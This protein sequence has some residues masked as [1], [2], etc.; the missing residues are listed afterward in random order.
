VVTIQDI[1]HEKWHAFLDRI[2]FHDIL[3]TT[4]ALQLTLQL[5]TEYEDYIDKKGLIKSANRLTKELIE[6]ILSQR[7]LIDAESNHYVITINNFNSIDIIDDIF[8]TYVEHKLT[9][10]KTLKIALSSKSIDIYS[11]RTLLRLILVN[12]TK[13]ALEATPK[14]GTVTIGCEIIGEN[15]KFW[16]HN[17]GFIPRDIQLQIFNRS[18]STKSQDRGLGTYSMK[19]LSSIL[20]GTI[21]FTTSEENGTIFNAEYPIKLEDE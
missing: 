19:L 12:M 7:L 4:N 21:N 11:D 15:I 9:E 2:F 17:P 14:D 8:N 16:V 1:Q 20:K 13:N 5:F 3:N 18:F 6:E 10:E